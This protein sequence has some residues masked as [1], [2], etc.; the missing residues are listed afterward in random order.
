M[1]ILIEQTIKQLRNDEI[2]SL[3]L[4]L[5]NYYT[6]D[7]QAFRDILTINTSLTKL[8]LSGF[9][10]NED[11]IQPICEGL[12]Q[13]GYVTTLDLS[14]TGRD[15]LECICHLIKTTLTI[16][17]LDLS[18]NGYYSIVEICEALQINRSIVT[19][20]LNY[21]DLDD[22]PE[23]IDS[24]SELIRHNSTLTNLELKSNFT[25]ETELDNIIDALTRNTT[26]AHLDLSFNDLTYIQI[27]DLFVSLQTNTTLMSLNLRYN[28]L[29]DKCIQI[30][31]ES[32]KQNTTLNKLDISHNSYITETGIQQLFESLKN[33]SSITTL[34]IKECKYIDIEYDQRYLF[35]LLQYNTTL[36]E[37]DFV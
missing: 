32:L 17:Y 28:S 1:S 2:T 14:N 5:S 3:K 11:T 20:K 9:C 37:I 19:F 22:S 24:L 27:R 4:N 12:E 8:D 31:S 7:K 21:Y 25:D 23:D 26:I 16:T 30:I 13:N 35:E 29:D 15:G 33:N 34:H 6:V 10:I 18:A 36:T